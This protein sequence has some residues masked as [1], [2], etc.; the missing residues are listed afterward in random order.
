MPMKKISI[1]FNLYQQKI[2]L[3]DKI[4]KSLEMQD[5]SYKIELMVVNKKVDSDCLKLIESYKKESRKI[6]VRIKKVDE[7]LSFASSMNEGIKSANT[8]IIIVLQQDCIPLNNNWL[9]NLI[10]PF[11]D[12]KVV[13][14]VSKV[15][16]PDELWN[17]QD[18]FTK[19]LMIREK[20]TINP[21]LDEKAC[22][23]RRFT[24]EKI[25]LF[26]DRDFRTAGEDFDMYIKLKNEGII[27]YPEATIIHYH[28]TDFK[29][30][31]NKVEQYAN[32]FGTLVRIYKSK[33]PHWNIGLLK[34][35]PLIGLIPFLAYPFKKEIKLYPI[36][37][38]LIP[39]MHYL[40]IKGFWKGYIAKSQS[41]DVFQKKP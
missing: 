20:G 33:V 6:E 18:I 35:T 38:L 27:S 39:L 11:T 12:E 15:K 21:L 7:N 36:Y 8:D 3:I 37:I 28:P 26:N 22:A 4:L 24:L 13:A 16:F 25:G 31:L 23:Y 10:K 30:R 14:T 34:A 5:S 19:S 41:I 17:N 9:N 40:Y 29:S 2:D 1:V 32:G